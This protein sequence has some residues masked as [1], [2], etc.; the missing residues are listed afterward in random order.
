MTDCELPFVVAVHRHEVLHE[1]TDTYQPLIVTAIV[2]DGLGPS[3]H[4]GEHS[5]GAAEARAIAASVLHA[6]DVIDPQ[7]RERLI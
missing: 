5:F 7:R 3:V 4:I 1:P 2:E 6:A